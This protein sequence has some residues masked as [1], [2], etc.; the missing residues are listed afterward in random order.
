MHT[1]DTISI[2][3]CNAGELLAYKCD[4]LALLWHE[5]W[6]DCWV[7][8][9]VG[10]PGWGRNCFMFWGPFW[11]FRLTQFLNHCRAI[12]NGK[13]LH[14]KKE[15]PIHRVADISGVSL[16]VWGSLAKP[17]PCWIGVSSWF[18]LLQFDWFVWMHFSYYVHF[19]F[20]SRKIIHG[21]VLDWFDSVSHHL[22]LFCQW[23][24]NW[25]KI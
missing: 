13:G 18:D 22:Q 17:V 1:K 3:M 23:T 20:Y 8:L 5:G 6:V 16:C 12:K 9:R 7:C 14:S 15:V 11:T 24:H 4:L 25:G 2:P 10:F 19:L 21:R